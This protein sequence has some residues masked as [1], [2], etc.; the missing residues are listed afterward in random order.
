LD[1]RET[2]L[3]G[4]SDIK[5]R[6]N[7]SPTTQATFDFEDFVGT[8]HLHTHGL[9]LV[10]EGMNHQIRS[11][12]IDNSTVSTYAGSEDGEKGEVDGPLL[13]ARFNCLS[14]LIQWNDSMYVAD[15]SS[16]R[17]ICDGLVSTVSWTH[18]SK[19]DTVSSICMAPMREVLLIT[20]Q[21]RSAVYELTLS[22]SSVKLIVDSIPSIVSAVY[23]C[24]SSIV[25]GTRGGLFTINSEMKLSKVKD[26]EWFLN[27]LKIMIF[28][29]TTQDLVTASFRRLVDQPERRMDITTYQQTSFKKEFACDTSIRF[30]GEDPK[31]LERCAS[32]LQEALQLDLDSLSC[33]AC[34]SVELSTTI[35]KLNNVVHKRMILD[36]QS[37]GSVVRCSLV[38]TPLL[39]V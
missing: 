21:A 12:D 33:T 29:Q 6:L 1:G 7:A 28:S 10:A 2:V 22:D 3:A 13:L 32:W 23:S 4:Q 5:G 36:E 8:L 17:L 14:H 19:F 9:I 30:P 20:D 27:G 38:P 39:P 37:Q 25:I 11:V 34:D 16:I 15:G 35:S 18:Q 24:D 31:W 26:W